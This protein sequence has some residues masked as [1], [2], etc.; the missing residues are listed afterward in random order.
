M[1]S[2]TLCIVKIVELS[3]RLFS[4][5]LNTKEQ[6]ISSLALLKIQTKRDSK[7][8]YPEK[9]NRFYPMYNN[10]RII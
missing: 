1:M 10:N 6:E 9:L 5:I 8:C 3:G 4:L 2:E 7:N